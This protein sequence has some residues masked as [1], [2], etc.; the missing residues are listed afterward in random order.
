MTPDEL[1]IRLE[2]API[3]PAQDRLLRQVAA[4]VKAHVVAET[5]A[6]TG[7]LRARTE[8]YYMGDEAHI[9]NSA[10]YAGYVLNGTGPH[11]ILPRTMRALAWPTAGGMAFAHSVNHP[12]TAPNDFFSAGLAAAEGDIARVEDTFGAEFWAMVLK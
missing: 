6:R 9:T 7:N 10:P 4:V 2:R 11:T 3:G 8:V 5:P 1:A 12:G